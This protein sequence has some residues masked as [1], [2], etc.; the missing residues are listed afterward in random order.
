ME[1]T[2]LI[3]NQLTNFCKENPS[4]EV[5]KNCQDEEGFAET[6][7]RIETL[8]E[9]D[10]KNQTATVETVCWWMEQNDYSQE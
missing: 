7:E 5:A 10:F 6:Q 3:Q 1:L 9:N 8:L 2:A 4:T